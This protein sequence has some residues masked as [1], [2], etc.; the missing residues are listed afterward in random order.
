[1]YIRL[2]LISLGFSLL[3]LS[4]CASQ[5]RVVVA[6]KKR[7]PS[8]Y[9]HPPKSSASELYAVGSGRDKQTAITNAL[10]HMVSTLSVS[11][12]PF[13]IA[14]SPVSPQQTRGHLS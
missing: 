10:T 4:G 5:K 14:G 8:W 13:P 6:E 1:M 9:E 11:V 7:I 3:F 2:L 12:H